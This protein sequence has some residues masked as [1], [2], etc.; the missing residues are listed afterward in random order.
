LPSFKEEVRK[1]PNSTK[2]QTASLLTGVGGT[3]LGKQS[4]IQ[5]LVTIA[6]FAA[7]YAQGPNSRSNLRDDFRQVDV[8][9]HVR[10]LEIA[11]VDHMS[12]TSLYRVTCRVIESF[13]G[14]MKKGKTLE[15]FIQIEDGYDTQQYRGEK[16]VFLNKSSQTAAPRFISLENSDREPLR[17]VISILRGFRH[18]Q[19]V[20]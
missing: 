15:Y 2:R 11:V 12:G 10:I 16:I 19:P 3:T 1:N 4:L 6:V 8:V 7:G 14:T 17:G 13:K 5:I 20:H 9:A 18:S